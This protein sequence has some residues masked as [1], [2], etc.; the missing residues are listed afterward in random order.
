ME[1]RRYILKIADIFG[2]AID[3]FNKEKVKGDVTADIPF[4]RAY[5]LSPKLHNESICCF[6]YL[7][8]TIP[9]RKQSQLSISIT[10]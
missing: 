2:V 6:L 3:M 7:I 9:L 8:P 1:L 5:R 4:F 10:H